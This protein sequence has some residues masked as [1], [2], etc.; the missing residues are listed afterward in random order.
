MGRLQPRAS[1][2]ALLRTTEALEA[3]PFALWHLTPAAAL[4]ADQSPLIVIVVG[5]VASVL[6]SIGLW[7]GA[8]VNPA[9][10]A[11]GRAWKRIPLLV[12]VLGAFALAF[13][14]RGW[15]GVWTWAATSV[16]AVVSGYVAEFFLA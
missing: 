9:T 2:S 8:L 1:A 12:V 15:T 11:L 7:S 10:A 13:Y 14:L 5:I 4:A 3:I 6:G 16:G